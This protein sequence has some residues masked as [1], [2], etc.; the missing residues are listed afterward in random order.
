MGPLRWLTALTLL[1]TTACATPGPRA[2]TVSPVDDPETEATAVAARVS[3]SG[4]LFKSSHLPL[5]AVYFARV[6]GLNGSP[7]QPREAAFSDDGNHM[8]SVDGT[9]GT[10]W[11]A[12]GAVG[13][14]GGFGA[15]GDPTCL[16]D[17]TGAPVWEPVLYPASYFVGDMVFLIN[18]PPGRYML[19]AVRYNNGGNHTTIYLSR[20]SALAT[21]AAAP[22]GEAGYGGTVRITHGRFGG[23]DPLQ[24]H[25]RRQ[26]QGGDPNK[27]SQFMGNLIAAMGDGQQ[28][29][30]QHRAADPLEVDH[31][32]PANQAFSD[33]VGLVLGPSPWV[34]RFREGIP[35]PPETETDT[36]P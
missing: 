34:P 29:W 33:A 14:E 27:V 3:V 35:A 32:A 21:E 9:S 20:E 30:F 23:F 12:I 10:G 15:G 6:S 2:V 8:V 25:F 22:P 13:T 19:A 1:L 31:S 11:S 16:Y 24:E 4:A 17:E 26:L 7:C 5:E 18:V 36:A 28:T